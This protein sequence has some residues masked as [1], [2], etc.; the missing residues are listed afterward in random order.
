MASIETIIVGMHGFSSR[1]SAVLLVVNDDVESI[2][3]D[4][5]R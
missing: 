3:A 4:T 2:V 5:T 1:K